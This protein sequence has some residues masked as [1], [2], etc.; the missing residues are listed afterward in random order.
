MNLSIFQYAFLILAS[1]FAGFVDSIAGGGGLITVPSFLAVGIPPHLALGTNKLQSTFG[2][3]TASY[4]YTKSGLVK[5]LTIWNGILW[6][7][8]GASVGTIVI[9]LISSEILKYIIPCLLV[10]IFV[11]T[12]ISPNAGL[13]DRHARISKNLFYT[14][15]GLML[16][17]YDG[18][19]GPGTG[20]FWALAI[21][22]FLG[23]NLQSATA[24]TK[25]LN[26][27]SNA[28]SLIFFLIGG[29]VLISLGCIT[30]LA[31]IVGATIGSHLVIKKGARFVRIVFLCVVGATIAKLLWNLWA[32]GSLN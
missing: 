31:Q 5:P 26:C 27:V 23:M 7:F 28:A 9:Q 11:Y 14:I 20:S 16:G 2:A 18:F 17:F 25:I 24:H 21:V 1:F 30:G 13:L 6:T 32:Q 3:L 12:L 4:H 15:F 19:F 22:F 8:L 29:N 10:V